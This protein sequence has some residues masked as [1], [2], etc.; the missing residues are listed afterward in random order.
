L[1]APT[2]FLSRAEAMTRHYRLAT[3]GMTSQEIA[4]MV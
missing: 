3:W 1:D 4:D 2:G